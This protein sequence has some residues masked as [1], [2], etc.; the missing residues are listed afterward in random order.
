MVVIERHCHIN[1]LP[2]AKPS[3]PP[4]HVFKAAV[5]FFLP[6]LVYKLPPPR[7]KRNEI[8]NSTHYYPPVITSGL[9]L[10]TRCMPQLQG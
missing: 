5:V 2:S 10:W 3:S 8:H 1:D 7:V 9:G 4:N 6:D